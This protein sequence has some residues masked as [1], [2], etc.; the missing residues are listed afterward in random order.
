MMDNEVSKL[1]GARMNLEQQMFFIE[2]GAQKENIFTAL[3]QG[4]EAV[5]NIYQGM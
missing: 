2:A 4:N 5:K 3:K 1:E